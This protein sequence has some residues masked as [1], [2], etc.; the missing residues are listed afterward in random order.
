MAL[1]QLLFRSGYDPENITEPIRQ[2]T[3]EE[4]RDLFNSHQRFVAT[5][6][7]RLLTEAL[8]KKTAALIYVVRSNIAHSEKTPQGPDL[9]KS[10]RDRIVSEA[11]AIVIEDLFDFLFGRPSHHL[12]VYGTLVPNA[13][14]A[15]ELSG[16]EGEWHEG[17][18]NGVIQKRDGFAEFSWSLSREPVPVRVLSCPGLRDRFGRLDRFEG[19]RYRRILVPVLIDGIARISNIYEGTGLKS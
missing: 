2:K 5:P 16:L 15:Q 3:S 6:N 7:D 13:P 4:H 11:T 10:E 8:L 19:P 17:E 1:I 12:A 14:N 9:A 18:V